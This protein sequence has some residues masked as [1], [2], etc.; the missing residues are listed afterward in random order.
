[1]T[2]QDVV[3]NKAMP[4][5]KCHKVV[6]ALKIERVAHLGGGGAE[7]HFEDDLHVWVEPVYISKHNPQVGGYFI[8][9]GDGYKS[10]SPAEAFEKGYSRIDS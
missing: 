2:T 3:A 8:V 1:M 4:R 9:Y 7:L 5:W 6:R 10:W